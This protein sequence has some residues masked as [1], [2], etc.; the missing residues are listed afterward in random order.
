M[1]NF[2]QKIE[3]FTPLCEQE[4]HDRRLMLDYINL[5]TNILD[6]SN[7]TLHFTASSWIVNPDRS[8]VLMVYHNIYRSWSWTGGHADGESDLLGVAIREAKEE[9]GI[10]SLRPVSE[11]I[12]SLEI[13][14][15]PAHRKYNQYVAPHLHLNLTYILEANDE[16][17]L[18]VKPDEN[19]AVQWFSL[20]EAISASTE[21]DMQVIYRKLNQRIS[22]QFPVDKS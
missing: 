12:F 17:Q 2:R 1:F 22:E 19:S 10:T 4:L 16:Q 9:T 18:Q 3:S 15:V 14:P 20:E 5:F 11:N 21:P 8:K 7:E 6:R 13:L